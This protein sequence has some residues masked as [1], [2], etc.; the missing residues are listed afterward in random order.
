ME[1]I[2]NYK[3]KDWKVKY[4]GL[5]ISRIQ[6]KYKSDKRVKPEIFGF[7]CYRVLWLCDEPKIIFKIK[8]IVGIVNRYA[9]Q[10]RTITRVINSYSM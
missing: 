1:T 6:D 2:L 10:S 9:S 3:L 7:K 4:L 5:V 8:S